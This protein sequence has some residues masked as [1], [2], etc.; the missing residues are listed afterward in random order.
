MIGQFFIKKQQQGLPLLLLIKKSGVKQES[1]GKNAHSL[2]GC[3]NTLTPVKLFGRDDF[4]YM[5][6]I[7]L[8]CGGE[9]KLGDPRS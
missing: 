9:M 1:V 4:R 8:H 2:E 6:F 5:K 3:T 7:Y